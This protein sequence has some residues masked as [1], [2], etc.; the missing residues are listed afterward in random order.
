MIIII[1]Q[2]LINKTQHKVPNKVRKFETIAD[3]KV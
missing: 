3:L 2:Y 1:I